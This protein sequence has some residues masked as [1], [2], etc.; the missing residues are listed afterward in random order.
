MLITLPLQSV[1]AAPPQLVAAMAR[2]AA[3][4][5]TAWLCYRLL[6]GV[7]VVSVRPSGPGYWGSCCAF[8]CRFLQPAQGG[9][10]QERAGAAGR[11]PE[12]AS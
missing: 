11:V 10:V 1:L 8:V 2:M 3:G 12:Q 9:S 4:D 6:G 5:N 7:T